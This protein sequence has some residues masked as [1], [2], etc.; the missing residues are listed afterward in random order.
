MKKKVNVNEIDGVQYR[1]V[2]TWQI[3]F[4][5]MN[6]GS[7]MV[8]YILMGMASYLANVGYGVGVAL[9]GILLTVSRVFD[10][11]TD[12]LIALLI[13]R[14][15]TKF[16][17]IR[18]LLFTG[19]AIE[20][21][22]VLVLFIWGSGKDHGVG[23]FILA[24]AL[25]VIGYTINSV[26]GNI[27]PPVMVNNP[28][29]RPMFNVWGTIYAYFVPMIMTL[30]VTMVILPKFGNEYSVPM[31]ATASMLSVAVSFVLVVLSMIGVSKA[32][33]PENFV[34]I[35]AQDG[36]EKVSFKDM[37]KLLKENKAMQSYIISAASDKL[38]QQ[39][40]SQAVVNTMLFGILIGN[41]QL[42]TLV[43]VG[44]MLP[45]II[46]AFI[47]AKYAGKHGNKEALITWT[48]IS[49]GIAIVGVIFALTFDLSL[50]TVSILPTAIFFVITLLL[51]GSKM[52]VTTATGAMAAD[53]VDYEL[54]RS[55]KFI[56]AAVMA[57]YSFIDKTISSLGATFAAGAVALI[58]FKTV[59]PQPTDTATTA[60]LYMTIFLYY[61]LPIL[62]WVTTLIA[63]KFSPL[64]REEMVKVQQ[65]IHDKKVKLSGEEVLA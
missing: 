49:L 48:R 16:G 60:I 45:S 4:A 12:P 64:S 32:D 65:N 26:T 22:A 37:I 23:F 59:M 24:Y 13:D 61:I 27:M 35:H 50:I 3:A 40:G 44:A 21:L 31:L 20:S 36:E 47:G 18:I 5:Q 14:L 25:Y 17:K 52:C 39:T 29:Q 34:G 9:A 28:K 46:F 51:N 54:N 42:G 53:I 11:I 56:P 63:L 1:T 2:K 8:F 33:K 41:M 30:V 10:G 38:A 7:S 19:W 62:G 15:N 57:T 55:G 43:S 58:G 6:S